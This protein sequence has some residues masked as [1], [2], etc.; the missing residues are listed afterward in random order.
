MY[1]NRKE[2]SHFQLS[3]GICVCA[4]YLFMPRL[5]IIHFATV[6]SIA[7]PRNVSNFAGAAT[8]YLRRPCGK[9]RTYE[10]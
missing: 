8:K 2:C 7:L 6:H 3:C 5:G 4:S 1:T 9:Q 10:E